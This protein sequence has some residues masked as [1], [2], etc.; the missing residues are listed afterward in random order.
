M[1]EETASEQQQTAAAPV[2]MEWQQQCRILTNCKPNEAREWREQNSTQQAKQHGS[3]L[4]AI[5]ISS[6]T[7]C[8]SK[9]IFFSYPWFVCISHYCCRIIHSKWFWFIT[10]ARFMTHNP[11]YPSVSLSSFWVTLLLPCFVF[12]FNFRRFSRAEK[13]LASA[14]CWLSLTS[15]SGIRATPSP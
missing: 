12:K 4:A 15:V 9:N 8:R 5:I 10:G 6:K 14:R 11:F 2:T 7:I 1:S 3:V 13:S